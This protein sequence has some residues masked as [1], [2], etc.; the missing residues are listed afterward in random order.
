[1][2]RLHGS[3][4]QQLAHLVRADF[5]GNG[6]PGSET[7]RKLTLPQGFLFGA[8]TSPHQTEGDNVNSD[9]WALEHAQNSAIPEVS[10]DACDSYNHWREDMQL[11]HDNGFNAYRFGIEWARIQ[12]DP[13]T[14]DYQAVNHYREMIETATTLGLAPCITLYHFSTP[15]WFAQEGGWL[16]PRAVERFASYIRSIL[17]ILDSSV[18]G[19]V[20]INEPNMVSVFSAIFSGKATVSPD[21]LLPNP[22][23]SVVES[24][25]K[26]HCAA[27]DLLHKALP[28]V[29]IG[30]SVANQCVQSLPG[31]ESAAERYSSAIEDPF[32]KAAQEDDF[33]GVQAYTRTVFDSHGKK[34]IPDQ[35]A[36]T[37][38]GW[39]FYPQAVSEAV[40]KTH[41][42]IPHVP[43]IVTENGIST[44]DDKRRIAYTR[45]ALTGLSGLLEQGYPLRGYFHW[46]LLDN[47]E[48][49]SWKPTFG[50]V[51]VNRE[52]GRYER[53]AKPSLSWLGNWAK[54]MAF[55]AE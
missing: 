15:Q 34:I 19:I 38:N 26:A 14:V 47:Y 25:I 46:S 36:M 20:T 27:R 44:T 22:D 29:P 53:I 11:L 2:A 3:A 7:G 42:I 24:L 51:S 41:S 8:A 50:L 43:V 52:S 55:P 45:D 23:K 37:S 48:W 39:E 9:W 32:I 10:G 5:D 4:D 49:G 54:G 33:I 6:Y 28:G 17:P 1:M 18:A 12:P 30:W 13:E 35:N 21:G 40:K 16:S 31:G